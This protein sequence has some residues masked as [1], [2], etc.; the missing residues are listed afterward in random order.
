MKAPDGTESDPLKKN[1]ADNWAREVKKGDVKEFAQPE[2]V[3]VMS[4]I[5]EIGEAAGTAAL[6]SVAIQSAPI[7]LGGLKKVMSDPKYSLS[8]YGADI[9]N[10]G[11]DNALQ[12]GADAF[13]KSA[14]AGSLCAAVKSGQIQGPLADLS[15]A[16]LAGIAVVGVESAK[17]M[18]RWQ[19]GE[20]TGEQAASES[21]KVGLKTCASLAG[22][23]AG[24]ALIPIP[25][26]GGIIGSYVATFLVDQGID[27]VENSRSIQ[28]LTVLDETF[29]SH[30][31]VLSGIFEVNVN[32]REM[33]SRYNLIIESNEFMLR[34]KD[35][36]RLHFEAHVEKKEDLISKNMLI[37][38]QIRKSHDIWNGEAGK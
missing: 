6:I 17:A 4:H 12:I 26:V 37:E 8:Q 7:V 20:I 15:P 22:K 27:S 21:F 13:I 31:T 23:A 3:N 9:A 18:W 25:I 33:I 35:T 5:K 10:W 34:Q 24:Q 11:K 32:Y 29:N 38:E 19:N 14:I 2:Q 30:R 36:Q 28:M 16:A 1:E